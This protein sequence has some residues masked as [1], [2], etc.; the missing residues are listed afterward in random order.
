MRRNDEEVKGQ[1]LKMEED[2]RKK[3]TEIGKQ[4]KKYYELEELVDKMKVNNEESEK[5]LMQWRDQH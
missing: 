3:D 4:K 1:I 2:L 5:E